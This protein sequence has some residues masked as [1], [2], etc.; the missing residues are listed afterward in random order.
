MRH[1]Q[2]AEGW[3][4]LG[5]W[6]SANAE[7][8][9]ISAPMRNHRDVLKISCRIYV[10]AKKWEM[11]KKVIHSLSQMP[12]GIRAIELMVLLQHLTGNEPKET[13]RDRLYGAF[14]AMK[15]LNKQSSEQPYNP[16]VVL[17]VL[18]RLKDK[19]IPVEDIVEWVASTSP[20]E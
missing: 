11:V 17:G 14:Q 9:K 10:K 13:M 18:E 5:D 8:E 4:E 16:E 3:L 6:Q 19:S 2:A 1:L 12:P 15:I 7:L 20:I